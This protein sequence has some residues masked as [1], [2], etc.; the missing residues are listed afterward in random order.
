MSKTD[1]TLDKLRNLH[2][3]Y[4]YDES[5]KEKVP[6]CE[7]LNDKQI[8]II[9]D[10]IADREKKSE[11]VGRY[12]SASEMLENIGYLVSHKANGE[13]PEMTAQVVG[14]LFKQAKKII[15]DNGKYMR[16]DKAELQEGSEK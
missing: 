5:K 9:M 11:G 7:P 6:L 16:G 13:L 10:I 2:K 14:N 15:E 8:E 1:N 12:L 3:L 4:V